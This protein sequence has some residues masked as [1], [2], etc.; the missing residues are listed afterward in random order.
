MPPDLTPDHTLTR[1]L[2][3]LGLISLSLAQGAAGAVALAA[4]RAWRHRGAGH[5]ARWA[6]GAWLCFP[7]SFAAYAAAHA[8]AQTAAPLLARHALSPWLLA[9]AEL[10]AFGYGVA[11]LARWA[12]RE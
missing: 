10:A 6:Q 5:P 2:L 11:R 9:P 7:L 1:L 3:W 8:A 12:A 4:L